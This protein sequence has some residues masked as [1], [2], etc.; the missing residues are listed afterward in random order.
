M[1]LKRAILAVILMFALVAPAWAG[2][3]AGYVAFLRGDFA[4]ALEELLPIAEEG[5]GEAQHT[6]GVMYRRGE[7][8]SRDYVEAARWWRLAA[9]QG[10]ISG[11]IGMGVAYR[12]GEGVPQDY[13]RA[14]MWFNLAAASNDPRDKLAAAMRDS[15]AIEMTPA[16]IAEAQRLAREWWEKHQKAE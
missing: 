7:G 9:E 15:L 6:I 4:T 13:A 10:N 14:H 1:S 12:Y 8:V 3:E 2:Y 5:H 11:Q 16:Q